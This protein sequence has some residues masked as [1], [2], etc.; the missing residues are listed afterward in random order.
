MGDIYEIKEIKRE[1]ESE[2]KG[3]EREGREE[4]KEKTIFVLKM[5]DKKTGHNVIWQI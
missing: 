4:E 3:N 2:R 5:S 1:R